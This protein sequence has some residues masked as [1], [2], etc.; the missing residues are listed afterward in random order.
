MVEVL[1]HWKVLITSVTTWLSARIV[2]NGN[3]IPN[4]R[5]ELCV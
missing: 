4:V 3:E 5:Y 1:M 2:T